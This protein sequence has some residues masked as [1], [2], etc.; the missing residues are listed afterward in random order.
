MLLMMVA[1][2]QG[3]GNSVIL[4][5]TVDIARRL[6]CH[7]SAPTRW[8]VKGTVLRDGSRL[9]LPAVRTPLGWRVDPEDL[10]VF[11]KAIAADRIRPDKPPGRPGR[12]PKTSPHDAAVNAELAACGFTK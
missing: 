1:I 2:A 11:L 9:R 5:T 6:Q 8:I 7:P 12:K 10:D 3:G 4:L